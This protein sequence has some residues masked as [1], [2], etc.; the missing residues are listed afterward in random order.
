M[1]SSNV[2]QGGRSET[3]EKVCLV[4]KVCINILA[5]SLRM[6]NINCLS[7]ASRGTALPAG[8]ND[9]PCGTIKGAN[10][11]PW[12]SNLNSDQREHQWCSIGYGASRYISGE[13][14]GEHQCAPEG[15]AS[16]PLAPFRQPPS[17]D[18]V[19]HASPTVARIFIHPLN[20]N[21]IFSVVSDRPHGV[22]RKHK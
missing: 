5:T 18:V 20:R 10:S 15:T 17:Q 7:I 16:V 14:V 22:P 12:L 3:T 9:V 6:D 8:H 2:G 21:G 1:T 4:F 19:T 13:P 11:H